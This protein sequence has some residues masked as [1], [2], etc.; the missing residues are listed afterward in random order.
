M[1]RIVSIHHMAAHR[2]LASGMVALAAALAVMPAAAERITIRPQ[3]TPEGTVVRLGDVA[4]IRAEDSRRAEA[5]AV[6]AG[7]FVQLPMMFVYLRWAERRR[8]NLQ[9][10][11]PPP[12]HPPGR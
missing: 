7:A 6:A 9:A 12:P 2:W 1:K 4:D 3:A 5:L 10:G 11:C 8:K